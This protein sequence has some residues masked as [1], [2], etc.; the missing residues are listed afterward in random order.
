M[1]PEEGDRPLTD[2]AAG[3]QDAERL[4]ALGIEAWWRGELEPAIRRWQEA[5]AA[6]QR[7]GNASG[8]VLAA[9]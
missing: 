1:N 4:F 3:G 8:S 7:S 9:F 5:F 2:A 6:F